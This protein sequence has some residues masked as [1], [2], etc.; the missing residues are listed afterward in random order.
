[1]SETQI[2]IIQETRQRT[3]E[4]APK[5]KEGL[6]EVKQQITEGHGREA[7][8]IIAG[9]LNKPNEINLQETPPE[10]PEPIQPTEENTTKP[11]D[12]IKVNYDE[13]ANIAKGDIFP[14]FKNRFTLIPEKDLLHLIE[15]TIQLINLV[16]ESDVDTIFF[17][18]K[19]AR[20]AAHLF[21]KTWKNFFPNNKPPSIRFVNI[22][23]KESLEKHN[24]PETLN[25]LRNTF[26][27]SVS[28]KNVLIADEYSITGNVLLQAFDTFT[29]TFPEAKRISRTAIY[30]SLP[31]WYRKDYLI[32]VS[33]PSFHEPNE[34][35]TIG[36]FLTEPFTGSSEVDKQQ[37][38]Q[39][40]N[41]FREELNFLADLITRISERVDSKEYLQRQRKL[42]EGDA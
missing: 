31:S 25:K 33:D 11:T 40:F 37:A 7:L 6:F 15:G 13:L 39:Q 9:W 18:D 36:G 12:L 29:K 23:R 26:V 34:D 17:L 4:I 38:R 14:E 10:S 8:Q 22:G 27:D 21:R 30:R 20:P 42:K 32:G 28:D 1:M 5:V 16:I 35:K 41:K 2:G 24:D 19:S 3:K